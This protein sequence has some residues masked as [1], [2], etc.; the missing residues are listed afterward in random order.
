M[1]FATRLAGISAS[2]TIAV[3]QEAQRLKRQGVDVIDFGPGEPDFPTPELV[4]QCGIEAIRANFTKYTASSGILELRQAVADKYNR[5]WGAAFTPD[6]VMLCAGAKQAV[7]NVCMAVFEQGHEVLNP[8]PYW[9]TFP[10]IVKITGARP[11]DLLTREEDGFVLKSEAVA[12]ALRPATR[13]LIVNT[14]NNPTGAVLP[15]DELR[16]IAELCR[17]RDLFLLSDE[18]YE[19]FTYGQRR[20]VSLASFVGPSDPFFAIVGSLSKTY[21]MTGWRIGYIVG[22]A[23]LIDKIG[24]F[25]SHASGNPSSISQKAALAAL[26]SDPALVAEMRQEYER[27]R[28]FVVKAVEDIPGFRCP[29]PDGAFYVFPNVAAC[30]KSSGIP[31]S[32][33]LARYLLQQARVTVVPGSAFGLEGYIRISYATSMDNLREGLSRIKGAVVRL[34]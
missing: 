11:V 31:N 5:E 12:S 9:V 33:E 13:G 16:N 34:Q 20:H 30:L 2:P 6:N 8:V 22:H 19:Y 3:M 24:E 14:P 27:R 23:E 32:Q 28:E 26:R 18:T 4:K 10:E 25:Q 15:A 1:K 29:A 21:S 7:Y 17:A